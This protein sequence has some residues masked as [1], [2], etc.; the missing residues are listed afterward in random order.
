[1]GRRL[2]GGVARAALAG[3][4]GRGEPRARFVEHAEG[5]HVPLH[6]ELVAEVLPSGWRVGDARRQYVTNG[7]LE[8]PLD[9]LG[10][11]T[12]ALARLVSALAQDPHP[13]PVL[14]DDVDRHLHPVW[15]QRIGLWLTEHFP[16]TQFLVATHSPYVCQ[17]ADPGALIR[18]PGPDEAGRPHRLDEELRQR[19]LYGSGEDTVLSEL[20]GL[21]SAYSPT[22]EAERRL[23]VRLERKMYAGRATDAELAEYRELGA[24]LNSSLTAR[25]DEVTARL[26]G[27]GE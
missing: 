1:M 15:Q 20:F 27:R 8:L 19:V 2:G 14:I 6:A 26:L 16:H 18:L 25:V 22:A 7:T 3:R 12:A 17:A 11:G 9:E 24:K 4:G 21:P 13:G 10:D 5:P 23:L